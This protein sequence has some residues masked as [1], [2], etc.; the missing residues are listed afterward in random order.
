MSRKFRKTLVC[1][2]LILAIGILNISPAFASDTYYT[3]TWYDF[4]SFSF[5]DYSLGAVK[6]VMGR[7]LT[8]S[9]YFH[10]PYWDTG[11]GDIYLK[12]EIRDA[13]TNQAITGQYVLG[14][15]SDQDHYRIV[16]YVYN[17]F[18]A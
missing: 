5:T 1:T 7:Y 17:C 3:G 16:S 18:H 8:I 10:K 11:I 2:L 12:F 14:R 13:T 9:L 15:Y 6:T 4:G